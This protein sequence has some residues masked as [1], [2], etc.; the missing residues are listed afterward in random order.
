MRH[1]V[2]MDACSAWS[3][4]LAPLLSFAAGFFTAIFAEPFRLWLF[5]PVL[6]IEFEQND[7]CVTKTEEGLSPSRHGAHFIRVKVTNLSS[8]IARDC[9]V[10]LVGFERRGPKGTWDPTDYCESLP[11]K[12]S[13]RPDINHNAIDLPQGIPHF[14]DVLSTRETAP[15][16]RPEIGF[17]PYR[18]EHLLSTP[19]TYKFTI[20]ATGDTIK[21]VT[22]SLSFKWTG[23]WDKFEVAKAG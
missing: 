22:L 8:R 2:A 17:L 20:M 23:D 14:V 5:R 7:H 21:P 10:Y 15:S 19:G 1:D 11:L 13:A 3:S 6:Q 4:T 18:I 16:F 9:R 12:W